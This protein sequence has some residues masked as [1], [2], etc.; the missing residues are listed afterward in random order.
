M[1][2]TDTEK[3]VGSHKEPK[4]IAGILVSALE[5]EDEI[6]HSIY[7]DYMD[8]KNWPVSLKDQTFEQIHMYLS[9]LLDDTQ[10]HR[11]MIQHLQSKLDPHDG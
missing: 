8:R 10:L 6:A 2:S 9:T 5:M 1:Q 3:T 4:K 7:N 11:N